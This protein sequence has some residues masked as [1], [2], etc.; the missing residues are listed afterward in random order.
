MWKLTLIAWLIFVVLKWIFGIMIDTM[1]FEEK[2]A[3][4]IR[5]ELPMRLIVVGGITFIE[6]ITTIVLAVITIIK[7]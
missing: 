5:N 1:S 7:L 4:K 3:C 2:V 6:F